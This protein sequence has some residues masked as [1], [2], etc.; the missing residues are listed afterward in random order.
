MFIDT[1]VFVCLAHKEV[2]AIFYPERD[3]DVER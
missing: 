2:Q 1:H 3:I